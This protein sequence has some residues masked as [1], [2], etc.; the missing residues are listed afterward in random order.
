[1]Q[2]V[3]AHQNIPA[4]IGALRP[5]YAM[6]PSE[7][8]ETV[9]PLA[10]YPVMENHRI[11]LSPADE[12]AEQQFD[13][14]RDALAKFAP[15][16]VPDANGWAVLQVRGI[17]ET[18]NEMPDFKERDVFWGSPCNQPLLVIKQAHLDQRGMTLDEAMRLMHRLLVLDAL[19]EG[20]PVP[21]AVLAEHQ[22]NMDE[23][24]ERE[25]MA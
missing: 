2:A 3:H 6:L 9:I 11:V 8:S 12:R 17:L 4:G 21:R 1:M 10:V 16:G 7:Y 20:L 23:G 18:V 13:R 24:A 19:D 25:V 22:L 15:P 14:L 5:L